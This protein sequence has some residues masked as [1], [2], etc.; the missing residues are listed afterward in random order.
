MKWRLG[1]PRSF[2]I[3]T[4]QCKNLIVAFDYF[5]KCIEDEP[6]VTIS[7]NKLFS[8]SKN[9]LFAGSGCLKPLL[10]RMTLISTQDNFEISVLNRIFLY[11]LS[12]LVISKPM[13][14]L[15]P[16]RRRSFTLCRS[17]W[18]NQW[19]TSLKN[20][21]EYI[22]QTR[23]LQGLHSGNFLPPCLQNWSS[24]SNNSLCQVPQDMTL[25]TNVNE[26]GL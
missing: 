2:P 26:E 9:L 12:Q 19:A 16:P 10:L 22:G 5:I 23:Q 15:K 21:W 11:T 13:D 18:T 17:A 24:N 25:Y 6:P 4:D 14:W 20:Y 1:L 7:S 8:S 3:A